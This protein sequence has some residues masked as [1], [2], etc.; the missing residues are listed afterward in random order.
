MHYR[1]KDLHQAVK[2]QEMEEH[3]KAKV[4]RALKEAKDKGGD[5]YDASHEKEIK[6]RARVK[7]GLLCNPCDK[8]DGR[9]GKRFRRS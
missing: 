1:Y 8:P 7:A 4:L 3:K 9:I 5:F 6:T 2:K